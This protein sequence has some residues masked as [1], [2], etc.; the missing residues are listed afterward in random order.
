MC[1]TFLKNKKKHRLTNI[2]SNSFS[3]FIPTWFLS[4]FN[5]K[6]WICDFKK[7]MKVTKINQ[8]N[9]LVIYL[10]INFHILIIKSLGNTVGISSGK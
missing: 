5:S 7:T 2:S 3:F 4:D 1:S 9:L 6:Y 8:F 10:K